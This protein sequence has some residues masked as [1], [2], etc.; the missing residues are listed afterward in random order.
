MAELLK[1][2]AR[3][4]DVT[5]ALRAL[6]PDVARE[7]RHELYALATEVRDDA[8]HDVPS[9][10]ASATNVGLKAS[11]S[12]TRGAMVSAGGHGA[13]ASWLGAAEG[14][15]PW[16]HPVFPVKGSDRTK[17]NWSKQ[18]QTPRRMLMNAW[19]RLG[20]TVMVRSNA[21]I[22]RAVGQAGLRG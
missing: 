10:M 22:D 14:A 4:G 18:P 12:G 17:W 15:S 13:P 6:A 20:A 5:K 8:R 1:V 3:F 16:K 2:D 11:Y 19:L 7:M 9:G 21:A